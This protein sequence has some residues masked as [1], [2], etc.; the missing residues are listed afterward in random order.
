MDHAS[1]SNAC[2]ICCTAVRKLGLPSVTE[3]YCQLS[4]I[5]AYDNETHGMGI[6]NHA[7]C[8]PA[9]QQK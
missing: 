7:I 8:L 5:L 3:G 2:E 1:W 9:L 6:S 4:P